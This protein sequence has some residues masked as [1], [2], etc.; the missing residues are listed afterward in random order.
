M[1]PG[2]QNDTPPASPPEARSGEE[3]LFRSES[4]QHHLGRTAEGHLLRLSPAWANWTYWLV[5]GVVGTAILYILIAKSPVYESGPAVL[6]IAGFAPLSSPLEGAIESVDVL[7]GQ[8]VMAGEVLVRFRAQQ[9]EAQLEMAQS[10]FNLQLLARLRDPN[11]QTAEKELRRLRPELE[12]A[13]ANL[14]QTRIR[15]PRD[16]AVQDVR[17]KPGDFLAVGDHVLSLAPVPAQFTVIAF[18]PGH[19][20]PQID[21]GM[22]VRLKI[23]GYAYAYV[24]TSIESVGKQV[25]GPSE[26]RRFLGS[27]LGDAVEL[28]GPVVVVGCKLSRDRFVAFQQEYR[29]HDGMRATAEVEV[30]RERLLYR[31]VPGLRALQQSDA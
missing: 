29:I 22:P 24:T 8:Q 13:K 9:E 23:G 14:E 16:G 25:I 11:D 28:S 19:A 10:E 6:R 15:A 3:G 12:R 18:L 31:L 7:P 26:A 5:V 4:L 17:I 20:L 30:R 2:P 21:V 1:G 27:D